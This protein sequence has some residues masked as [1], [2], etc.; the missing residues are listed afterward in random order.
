MQ[1][2]H[3]LQHRSHVPAPASRS[4]TSNLPCH[5]PI[6]SRSSRICSKPH[7]IAGPSQS[8]ASKLI[9]SSLATSTPASSF[10]VPPPSPPSPPPLSTSVQ[11]P[12]ANFNAITNTGAAKAALPEW[13][14]LLGGV[15]AGAYISFGCFLSLSVG[16]SIPGIATSNPGL[17]KLIMAMLFP[18]NLMMVTLCGAELYT[19]NTAVVSVAMFE[20]KAKVSQAL[21]GLFY[22]FLG[23]WI[24]CFGVAAAVAATGL[25]AANPLPAAVAVAKTSLDPQTAIVRAILCN[26]LVCLAVW[27]ASS[28]SSL[29]GKVLG[30]WPPVVAFFAIGLEHSIA[31]MFIISLGIML[32]AKV[33]F[34]QLWT[35]NLLPVTFGNTVA[36]VLCVALPYALLYGT[37]GQRLQRSS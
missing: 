16:G 33:T 15:L 29:P 14:S 37:L 34:A 3:C 8:T 30:L 13:K 9:C 24:G 2:Q 6:Q 36:G 1:A 27:M 7:N 22:S 19:G 4:C 23:N 21:K 5:L 32:G 18:V 17:Q 25:M 20:G 26:W 31:N 10:P 12:G 28:A 11:A 35:S